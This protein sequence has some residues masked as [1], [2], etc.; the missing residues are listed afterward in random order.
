[1]K[2]IVG[3]GNPGDRY[4]GSRHNLG[5]MVVDGLAVRWK[6]PEW[7]RRYR[8]EITKVSLPAG[9]ILL[10]KPQTYMNNSGTAVREI[11]ESCGIV[12]ENLLVIYDDLDLEVGQLRL[13]RKGSAGGHKGVSSIISCLGADDF[14]RLRVGIGKPPQGVEVVDYVLGGFSD[15]QWEIIQQVVAYACEAALVWVN[16]GVD[17]AMARFNGLHLKEV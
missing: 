10:V 2:A 4:A 11:S 15:Q 5:F 8:A 3:L 6:A 17:E 12:P 1:M 14:H 9:E 16:H 7:H 13:R